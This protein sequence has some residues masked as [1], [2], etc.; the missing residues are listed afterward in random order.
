MKIN[1]KWSVEVLVNW[2]L[3]KLNM[4]KTKYVNIYSYYDLFWSKKHITV[5]LRKGFTVFFQQNTSQLCDCVKNRGFRH[6]RSHGCGKNNQASELKDLV[7]LN[8]N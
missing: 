2:V 6:H 5:H 3:Y 4:H 1:V 8:P 7:Q